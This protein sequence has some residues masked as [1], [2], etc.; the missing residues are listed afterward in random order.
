MYSKTKRGTFGKSQVK[1]YLN[2]QGTV[3]TA[4]FSIQNK[5]ELA[6]RLRFLSW[7]KMLISAGRKN[8][9]FLAWGRARAVQVIRVR[10]DHL[11]KTCLV[12]VCPRQSAGVGAVLRE[13][14]A[15]TPLDS[16]THSL[17]AGRP[18]AVQML[19]FK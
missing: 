17:A 8:A 3:N 2:L 10:L 19:C 12:C 7:F 1:P 9:L 18:P 5:A 4:V 15:L 14:R 6:N 11:E 13:R 16:L